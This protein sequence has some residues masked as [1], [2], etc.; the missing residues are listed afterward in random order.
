MSKF[1]KALLFPIDE[2]H[3]I[4][5]FRFPIHND[6]IPAEVK[7]IA[8]IEKQ[9]SKGSYDSMRL[10]KQIAK[11]R[12][13]SN[14]EAVELL[15]NVGGA[16]SDSVVYD[17]IDQ[18]QALNDAQEDTTAK[19]QAYA[20]VLL[21]FRGQVKNPETG[22]WESTEDWT[23]EDTNTI[24]TKLLNSMFQFVLWE[25]DGWPKAD[26]GNDKAAKPSLRP[27]AT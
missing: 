9:Y 16:E 2:Y 12:N 20:L 26:E 24:P 23:V 4:G 11:D 3:E 14:R 15:Q 7:Q 25:R 8:A 19:L 18:I 22:E 17:Y 6:L 1:N 21:Q 10:A 5:P 13:I 27:K